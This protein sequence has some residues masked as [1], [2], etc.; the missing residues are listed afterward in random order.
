MS[1]VEILWGNKN[2][3]L[4]QI[5]TIL[6]VLDYITGVCIAIRMRKLSSTIGFRGISTKVLIYVILSTCNIM[7]NFILK[8]GI[9]IQ[10]VAVLFYCTNEIISILENTAKAGVPL[11]Q[12]LKDILENLKSS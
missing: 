6:V 2:T 4:M 8:D 7:D 11:P 9:S 1:I 12:K 3:T 5:L 10:S